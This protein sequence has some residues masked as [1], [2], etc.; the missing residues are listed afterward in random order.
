M[1]E[2]EF[3][4]PGSSLEEIE[5]ILE[6]HGQRDKPA[7]NEDIA[8]L[9]GVST[10]TVSRNN[11]FL[12]TVGLIKEGQKKEPTELGRDLG[13]ALH[14]NQDSDIRKYW[15]T[16]VEGSSFLS[17]QITAVRVQKGVPVDELPDNILYNSGESKNKYTKTGARTVVDILLRAGVLEKSD[18]E[19]TVVREP[20][21]EIER[22]DEESEAAEGDKRHAAAGRS[23]N[24]V[25]RRGDR[26]RDVAE[27][28]FQLAVN[29]QLQLPE[30]D[31]AKKYEE[32]FQALRKHL[33]E[34]GEES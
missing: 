13:R 22:E 20:D 21:S 8:K 15:K 17:E 29:L 1:A 19:Y 11:R 7:S 12:I 30:F 24:R 10:S 6:A 18:N 9:A 25:D 27:Q 16:V 28:P 5:K 26:L 2:E 23:N 4:L 34:G 14:H 32:L 31:D 33:L 3:K